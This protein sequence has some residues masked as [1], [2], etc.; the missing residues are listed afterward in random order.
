MNSNLFDHRALGR[1]RV[2]PERTSDPKGH[3]AAPGGPG[4]WLGVL[5]EPGEAGGW[6]KDGAI[7]IA[8][9]GDDEALAAEGFVLRDTRKY[10]ETAV[11]IFAASSV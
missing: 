6:L 1:R 9:T 10:G 4:G 7:V 8:E 11:H 3:E 5:A 2:A